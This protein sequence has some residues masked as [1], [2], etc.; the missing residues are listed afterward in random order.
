[1]SSEVVKEYF[2]KDFWPHV[3]KIYAKKRNEL[4]KY[5]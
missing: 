3:D 2:G 5:Y 1:M 4:T